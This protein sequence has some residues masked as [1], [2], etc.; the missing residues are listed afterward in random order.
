MTASGPTEHLGHARASQGER[1]WAFLVALLL[2][3]AALVAI[4]RGQRLWPAYDSFLPAV[5]SAAV[6]AMFVTALI[7]RNQYRASRFPPFAFLAT[8]YATTAAI[9]IPVIVLY[10]RA[11]SPTSFKTGT[12]T[13][14]WLW[15]EA[16][17][18]FILLLAAYVWAQSFFSRQAVDST[19]AARWVRGYVVAVIA[20]AEAVVISTI[21]FHDRL[22]VLL[23]HN[24]YSPLFHLIVE[25]ILLAF[26]AV[27]FVTLVLR[28]GLR[29]TTPLWLAVV[30]LA[31]VIET[32][33]S[34]EI[35]RSRFTI[36][37][38]SAVIAAF[39]WQTLL[40]SS[41][42]QHANEQMA[43]FG[44][45]T[46]TLIEETLRDPLTGLYNRR[47]FDDRFAEALDNCR[48]SAQPIGLI[49]LDLDF[50]KSFND[51]YGHIAGDEALRRIGDAIS[52]V[53]NRNEDAC[54]RIGG[55]EFA[56]VLPFTDEPGAL[57][58]AERVRAAVMR[59]KIP[60]APSVPIPTMTVSIGVAN[61]DGH[62]RTS[63][64]ELYEAADRAL[65]RAKRMGRN[66]IATTTSVGEPEESAEAQAG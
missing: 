13:P 58:V 33:M 65:Y 29:D 17:C 9:V 50:F 16:H 8:A 37:W 6:L 51:H 24:G 56:I 25:Q 61:N 21:V 45:Q 4:P 60:H 53:A 64:K 14:V 23:L 26:C 15:V 42:L 31:L 2:L 59:L 36:A 40:L 44:A 30:V 62:S 39:I 57:T 3:G 7:L 66:R 41:Q 55:E 35:V 48:T 19:I 34:G 32:Y 28:S 27:V 43:A 5:G 47:G 22:P 63:T 54:C 11:F 18:A 20:I 12:Q 1:W 46:R 49:A 52:G 10:P 38:Y